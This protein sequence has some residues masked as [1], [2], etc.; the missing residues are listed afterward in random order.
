MRH[1]QVLYHVACQPQ[2]NFFFFVAINSY[3]FI[4]VFSF[5]ARST[6]FY[7]AVLPDPFYMSTIKPGQA[8]PH[9]STDVKRLKKKRSG[10]K[11]QLYPYATPASLS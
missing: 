8:M 4:V 2:K 5:P 9:S 11:D 6:H 7:R 3:V 10:K 1:H